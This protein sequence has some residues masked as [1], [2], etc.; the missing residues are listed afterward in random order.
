MLSDAP[1]RKALKGSKPRAIDAGSNYRWS[2]K[3]KTEAVQ[4]YLTLGNLALTSRL[5]G[6]PEVT[7]RVWKKSQWWADMVA[8]MKAQENIE[9]TNRLKKIVDASLAV[10]EDRLVNGDF[11]YDQKSGEV[12]RKPVNMKDAHKVSVD[13]QARQDVLEKRVEGI[14]VESDAG[15]EDKLEKLAERFAQFAAQKLDKIANQER[16]I[17]IE[18]VIIKDEES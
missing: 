4:S 8:E 6:I 12:V 2:D 7:L 13:L 1:S 5:L 3:Q 15:S 18:D 10:V 11:Q 14:V 9:L 17:D 16:T